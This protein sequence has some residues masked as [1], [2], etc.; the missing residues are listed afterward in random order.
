M[1][2]HSFFDNGNQHT[3]PE[4][5]YITETIS[6]NFNI[7]KLTEGMLIINFNFI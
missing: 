2:F 4:S 1:H 7:N 6:E 3:T 5:D